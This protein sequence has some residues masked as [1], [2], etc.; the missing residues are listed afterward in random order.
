MFLVSLMAY[1]V[2]NSCGMGCMT[3]SNHAQSKL[4]M[5]L[6]GKASACVR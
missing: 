3:D 1:I 4:P 5:I 6:L 2:H